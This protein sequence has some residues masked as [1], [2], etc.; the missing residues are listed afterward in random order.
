MGLGLERRAAWRGE[1]G[2]GSGLGAV[3]EL[4]PPPAAVQLAIGPVVGEVLLP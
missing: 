1:G 2:E 4:A 3:R